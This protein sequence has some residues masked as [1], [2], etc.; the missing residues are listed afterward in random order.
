MSTPLEYPAETPRSLTP[1][2][3]PSS[4][5]MTTKDLWRL[6]RFSVDEYRVMIKAG[7]FGDSEPGELLEGLILWKFRPMTPRECYPQ[8]AF[9]RLD[10]DHI[11][12]SVRVNPPITLAD[13]EP[14]PDAAV[15]RGGLEDYSGRFATGSEVG[16]VVEFADASLVLCLTR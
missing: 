7:I 4:P 16:L 3:K 1:W 11:G 8:Q 9:M 5:N 10:L 6:R 13:S 14:E 12:W 15:I 2:P